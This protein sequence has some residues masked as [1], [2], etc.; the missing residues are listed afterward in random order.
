M[1]NQFV[2]LP[3][4]AGNGVGGAVDVSVMGATKTVVVC[5]GAFVAAVHIETSNDGVSWG[6]L[7]DFTTCD[8]DNYTVACQFM[9]V[10]VSGY[11]SGA[12]A[13]AV[14]A[15]DAGALAVSLPV[16][17][18]NGVGTAVDVSALGPVK[19]ILVAGSYQATVSVQISEDGV[20]YSDAESFPQADR[21]NIEALARFMRVRVSGYVSGTPLVSVSGSSDSAGSS[22][23]PSGNVF[24]AEGTGTRHIIYARL[25]GSDTTGTGTLANP[26]RTFARAIQDVPIFIPSTDTYVVDITGI[27]LEA[28]LGGFKLK[29]Y[30]SSDALRLNFT[31]EVPQAF[32]ETPLVIQAVPK[33]ASGVPVADTL[34]AVGEIVSQVPNPITGN[35]VLTTTKVWP[36]NAFKGRFLLTSGFDGPIAIASN[37]ASALE[38]CIGY[39][40]AGPLS[41]REPSAELQNSDP[42]GGDPALQIAE[43]SARVTLTG[44]RLSHAFPTFNTMSLYYEGFLYRHTAQFVEARDIVFR[45]AGSP[46]FW[47]A[48]LGGGGPGT[49]GIRLEGGTPELYQSFIHDAAFVATGET[50]RSEWWFN[51]VDSCRPLFGADTIDRGTPAMWRLHYCTVRNGSGHGIVNYS[52]EECLAEFCEVAGNAGHGIN[53]TGRRLFLNAVGGVGNLGVGVRMQDGN[54]TEVTGAMTVTGA[55]GD[56]QVG[57]NAVAPWATGPEIDATT[58][59]RLL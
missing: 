19:S 31:P 22:S 2:S 7:I 50:L 16:P 27:G 34:I 37:T 49:N 17:A 44:L 36:V 56:R 29:P 6:P 39:A 4:P 51:I 47:G 26:Y 43:L 54:Q 8:W 55:V 45:G 13:V 30:Q 35:I 38:L 42:A 28:R 48:S 18:G 10:R 11:K 46:L 33:P 59:T 1:P 41:I 14:G 57:N 9:R 5:G 25:T 21:E 52:G 20:N 3:V 53:T 12:P 24:L 23:G 32:A 58:F 40:I 15:S